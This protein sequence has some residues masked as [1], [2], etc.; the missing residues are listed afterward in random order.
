ME[1]MKTKLLMVLAVMFIIGFSSEGVVQQTEHQES[2]D[3][4]AAASKTNVAE[5]WN[6]G[7][8][9]KTG[10]T[11]I[12]T[13]SFNQVSAEEVTVRIISCWA[14]NYGNQA[15][16]LEAADLVVKGS[17]V[18]EIGTIFEKGK[19]GEY[20]TEVKLQISDVFKGDYAAG[21]RITI[22]QMGG[23]DGEVT[24]IG[25]HTTFLKEQQEVVLFLR[26]S[27]ES[28]YR[29]INENDGVYVL[30]DGFYKNTGNNKILNEDFTKEAN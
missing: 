5:N 21:D 20:R 30:V 6:G 14:V 25:D 19:Y 3:R 8:T 16:L 1:F 10:Q 13:E 17:V 12:S 22:A 26:Q 24:V 28:V 11:A 18:E 27:N 23:Y 7:L 2:S 9:R 29:P 4:I 15:A